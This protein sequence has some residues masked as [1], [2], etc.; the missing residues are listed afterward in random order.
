MDKRLTSE[1]I[2]VPII[3]NVKYSESYVCRLCAA[4]IDIDS[5]IS[6]FPADGFQENLASK[7]NKYLP[8]IVSVFISC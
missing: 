2:T 7:I 4:V 5:A 3:S 6:I 8:I 1:Y